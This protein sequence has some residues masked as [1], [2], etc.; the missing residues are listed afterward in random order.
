MIKLNTMLFAPASEDGGQG[1]GGGLMGGNP[2]A[3]T[4]A[5]G[6]VPP[7]TP[8]AQ[9]I[10]QEPPASILAE[11]GTFSPQWYAGNQDI[12]EFGKQLDKFATPAALAKS[13]ATL[14]RNRAVPG[15]GADEHAIEAFRKANGIP[16]TP[17]AYDLKIP[18]TMPD[19]VEVSDEALGQYKQAFH[20]LNLTPAQSQALMEKHIAMTGEQVAA[21]QGESYTQQ[22][23]AAEALQRE[24]GNAYGA[25]LEKAQVAFDNLC[26]K[27][28]VNPD[29]VSFTSDPAFAKIMAQVANVT[30]ESPVHGG[31]GAVTHTGGKQEAHEIMTNSNHPDYSAFYDSQDPRHQEVFDRVARINK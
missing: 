15:L 20:E 14:E 6:Q 22:K 29:D 19:G 30:S 23:E 3:E 17:E 25:N 31:G 18:E 28:G 27:A 24:W 2:P 5:G 7:A 8:P 26:A 13:Y 10:N 9:G 4:P 12:A 21:M 16:G 1:G 11:D